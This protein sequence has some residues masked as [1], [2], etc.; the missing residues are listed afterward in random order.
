MVGGHPRGPSSTFLIV[1]GGRSGPPASAPP[2]GP[3]STFLSVD[4]G[5]SRISSSGT[6]R[7]PAVDCR[8]KFKITERGTEELAPPAGL[9]PLLRC[10]RYPKDRSPPHTSSKSRQGAG[11]ACTRYHVSCS[12][13]PHLPAEVGSGVTTCPAAPDLASVMR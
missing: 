5:R 11:R 8:V 12:F 7:G 6:F 2:E 9:Q 3:P 1:D 13:G 4:G 10:Y